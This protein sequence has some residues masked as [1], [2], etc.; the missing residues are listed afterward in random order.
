MKY[1]HA[2]IRVTDIAKSLNFYQELLGLK[3]L[4]KKDYEQ[5]RFSLYYLAT[6]DG[7]PEI[8]LT[9]NWGESEYTSGNS[10]GHLAFSVENI[11][12]LCEKLERSGVA[13]LRPPRDGHMA[14]IK[15]PS[16]VSIELLQAGESL[17]DDEKWSKMESSGSW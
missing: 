11:Y 3:L 7:E 6:D 1:L 4:R 16:G 17:P 10:F 9:H 2:M 14:F 8:E 15:D 12:D 5:G 13:I